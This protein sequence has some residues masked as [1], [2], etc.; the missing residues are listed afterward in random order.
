MKRLELLT[1]VTIINKMTD[2][3]IYVW[4]LVC[5]ENELETLLMIW[6]TVSDAIMS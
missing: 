6:I 2:C 5:S 3:F 1:N 4:S